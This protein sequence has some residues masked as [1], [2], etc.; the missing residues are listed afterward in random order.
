MDIEIP[1]VLTEWA[2]PIVS[3]QAFTDKI[4]ALDKQIAKVDELV[5]VAPTALI[6]EPWR[7]EWRKYRRRWEV[8]RDS[9]AS[10]ITR[11]VAIEGHQRLARFEAG[12]VWWAGDLELRAKQLIPPTAPVRKPGGSLVKDIIEDI[13]PTP[14]WW[15]LGGA[16]ALY[17]VTRK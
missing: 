13:T 4:D 10:W 12:W 16:A 14:V 5:N 2:I 15:I 3:Y 9:R 8:W 17:V 6:N 1:T 11:V 7:R